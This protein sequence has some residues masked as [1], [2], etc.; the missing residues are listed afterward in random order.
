MTEIEISFPIKIRTVCCNKCGLE[1]QIDLKD[2]AGQ[3]NWRDGVI[4]ARRFDYK[5]TGVFEMRS[6]VLE[7]S[8]DTPNKDG[9]RIEFDLC[10]NCYAEVWDM[11]QAK[12]G[13]FE[14]E[15]Y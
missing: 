14:S 1:T 4:V 5:A 13:G 9:K 11:L 10:G 2:R 12:L 6:L 8:Y 7:G 3:V 15:S